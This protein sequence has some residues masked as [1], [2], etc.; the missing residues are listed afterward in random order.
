MVSSR[1]EKASKLEGMGLKF[2]YTASGTSQQNGRAE[3]KFQTLYGR[4]RAMLIGSG[5]QQPLRNSLWAE[6]VNTATE[7]DGILVAQGQKLSPYQK[8][9]GKGYKSIIDVT[10]TFGE[11]CIVANQTTIKNKLADRGKPCLWMGY[12]KDHSAGTFRLYNPATRKVILSRDVTFLG[13]TLEEVNDEIEED[14]Q[15]MEIT[16]T[17][18]S[19]LRDGNYHQNTEDDEP[20]MPALIPRNYVSDD[21]DENVDDTCQCLWSLLSYCLCLL[22]FLMYFSI[23]CHVCILHLSGLVSLGHYTCLELFHYFCLLFIKVSM[24]S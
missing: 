5:I 22:L 16:P 18:D 24:W 23:F 2:E 9:F 13:E 3:R 8:F 15:T 17:S 10:K 7:L 6:A 12:A 4:V 19:A 21:E 11:K 20:E 14:H 1:F